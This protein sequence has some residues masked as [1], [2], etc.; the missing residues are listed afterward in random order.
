M[1]LLLQADWEP[2]LKSYGPLG[3]VFLLAVVGFISGARWLKSFVTDTLTDARKDRD[4]ARAINESQANKFM[5]SLAKRDEMMEK[6]FDEILYEIRNS[7][8]N[9]RR[10]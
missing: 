6:G 4:T 10:K 2:I 1:A 7:Q 5:E 9:P 8:S 3:V